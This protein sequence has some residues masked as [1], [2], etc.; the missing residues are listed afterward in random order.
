MEATPPQAPTRCTLLSLLPDL[1]ALIASKL[2]HAAARAFAA[3]STAYLRLVLESRADLAEF[4]V[5]PGLERAIAYLHSSTRVTCYKRSNVFLSCC[6]LP[7]CH[8]ASAFGIHVS[9]TT[10]ALICR[11]TLRTR[12]HATPGVA[13]IVRTAPRA[14]L[15]SITHIQFE[16]RLDRQEVALPPGMTALCDATL[17]SCRLSHACLPASS[18]AALRILHLDGSSL[19]VLPQGLT[20]LQWLDVGECCNLAPN[21]LPASSAAAL[22]TL[23]LADSNAERVPEGMRALEVISVRGCACLSDD[24]WLPGSS[25]AAVHTLRMQWSTLR[26]VPEGMASLRVL[27]VQHCSELS[28]DWLP[29]SSAAAVHTLR[30]QWCTLPCVPESMVSLE[31]LDAQDCTGLAGEWLPASSAKRVCTVDLS[32]S[33][34]QRLP[35]GMRCL[36]AITFQY[37]T[38]LSDAWLPPSSA[39]A[40]RVLVL[41]TSGMVIAIPDGLTSL[42]SLDVSCTRV[43]RLPASLTKLTTLR[44]AGCHNLAPNWLPASSAACIVSL[45]ARSSNMRVVPLGMASLRNLHVASSACLAPDGSG[46]VAYYGNPPGLAYLDVVS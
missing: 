38:N 4:Q 29:A 23:H 1:V 36:E 46:L 33:S 13:A 15:P 45:D 17:S 24:G 37:F 2:T 44:V 27:D 7:A 16:L 25:A 5:A 18:A 40:V 20:A 14:A 11:H 21:W 32:G 28:G 19:A 26:R 34:V 3:T 30:M 12:A 41:S 39:A 6:Q 10:A 22:R 35:E 8:N 43:L 9:L 31:H 42:E